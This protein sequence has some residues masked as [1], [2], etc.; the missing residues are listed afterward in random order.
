MYVIVLHT[1]I[2]C[3]EYKPVY[4]EATEGE[5]IT[6]P[7]TGVIGSCIWPCGS[8]ELTLSLLK[9]SKGF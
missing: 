9:N 8:W 4:V 6:S 2:M 3:T 5:D 7:G 1:W